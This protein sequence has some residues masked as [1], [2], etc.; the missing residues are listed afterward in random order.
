MVLQIKRLIES[1]Q[2]LHIFSLEQILK[3]T[4]HSNVHIA[5]QNQN[6]FLLLQCGYSHERLKPVANNKCLS[7]YQPVIT[8][9]VLL[10]VSFEVYTI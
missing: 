1:T 5:F 8:I 2:Q 9:L 7:F 6:H 3:V 10:T 4:R